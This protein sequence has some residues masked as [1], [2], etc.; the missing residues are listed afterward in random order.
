MKNAVFFKAVDD[1]KTLSENVSEAVFAGRSNVGKSSVINALCRK[2]NLARIS[3]TPG[4]TRTVNVY[5]I[6]R[7]KWLMDLPGYGFARVSPQQKEQWRAM[8]EECIVSRKSRKTVYIIV[9][10]YVGPTE[11][12]LNMAQWL[13]ANSVPFKVIAN[14]CDKISGGFP[15]SETVRTTIAERFAIEET[16]IFCVSAKK[17]SGFEKLKADI[18]KFLD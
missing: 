9:D 14:K 10:A 5:S 11:L 7:G 1:V 18:K 3:K 8:I 4:R 15:V 2:K 6:S 17:N 12:D 16:R 13:F